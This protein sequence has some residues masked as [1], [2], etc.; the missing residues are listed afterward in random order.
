MRDGGRE[1]SELLELAPPPDGRSEH[2]G[3]A[4]VGPLVAKL[5]SLAPA[6]EVDLRAAVVGGAP[7][8]VLAGGDWRSISPEQLLARI[9]TH[10]ANDLKVEAGLVAPVGPADRPRGRIAFSDSEAMF[11]RNCMLVEGGVRVSA[12]GGFVG[13][14]GVERTS[15]SPSVDVRLAV[16][17]EEIAQWATLQARASDFAGCDP[18]ALSA[19][20]LALGGDPGPVPL[21]ES[22]KGPLARDQL[23]GWIGE[24]RR[25]LLVDTF[26]RFRDVETDEAQEIKAEQLTAYDEGEEW[27]EWRPQF[28]EEPDPPHRLSADM[29][30]VA[31]LSAGMIRGGLRPADLPTGFVA[32]DFHSAEEAI[33]HL[34]AIAWNCDVDEIEV[35]EEPSAGDVIEVEGHGSV[36]G[37]ATEL[38]RPSGTGR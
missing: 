4:A 32:D 38:I 15:P 24:R 18:L 30:D 8:T 27:E 12:T 2:A 19:K 9:A 10:P 6:Y 35:A 20:V 3:D 7:E 5:L 36:P 37:C 17:R 13:V 29:L 34:A 14:L 16:S 1:L 26:A 25:V 23:L 28:E 11:E 21:A 22:A 33:M 31:S